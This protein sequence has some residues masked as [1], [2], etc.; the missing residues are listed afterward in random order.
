MKNKGFTV[1]ELVLTISLV[2]VVM[3]ILF[4]IIFLVKNLYVESG[5][6][7]KLLQKQL[8]ISEKI[9]KNPDRPPSLIKRCK[10]VIR[11]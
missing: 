5:V 9:N 10:P 3:I 8:V 6:K 2:S 7:V 1:I 4:Q 11:Q